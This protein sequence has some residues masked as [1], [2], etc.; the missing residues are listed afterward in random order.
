MDYPSTPD[1]DHYLG[2]Y[3]YDWQSGLSNSFSYKNWHLNFLIDLNYGGIRTSA[4]ESMLMS[5]GGSEATLYGRDGFIF[6]GVKEDGTP[7]D[8][9]INAEAYGTLVGGRS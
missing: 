3:N 4:T 9:T 2:N 5:T 6:E 1:P 8:V 7:N